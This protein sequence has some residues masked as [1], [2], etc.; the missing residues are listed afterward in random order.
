MSAAEELGRTI[1]VAP[2]CDALTVSRASLYRER[3]PRLE[4]VRSRPSPQRALSVPERQVV[5]DVLH[6]DRFVDRAPAQVWAE[7]IDDGTYYCSVRTMYRLLAEH[8]EIRERRKIGRAH[9]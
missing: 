1:G 3:R 7:L 5:L 8:G 4:A 6:S 9:V 2:A